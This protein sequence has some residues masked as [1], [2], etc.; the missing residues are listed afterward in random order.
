MQV[1]FSLLSGTF[2]VYEKL[3]N[4]AHIVLLPNFRKT[5]ASISSIH[6]MFYIPSINHLMQLGFCL[7]VEHHLVHYNWTLLYICSVYYQIPT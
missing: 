6:R 5:N 1:N 2:H 3:Q 4:I 7:Y